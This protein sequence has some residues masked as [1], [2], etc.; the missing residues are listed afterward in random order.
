ML[1]GRERTKVCAGHQPRS[2]FS[3]LDQQNLMLA[4]KPLLARWAKWI[5][6]VFLRPEISAGL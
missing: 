4:M 3:D 6:Q 5:M 1:E 2:T